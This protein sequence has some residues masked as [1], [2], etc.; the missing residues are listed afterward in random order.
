M[1]RRRGPTR[2]G[3][4]GAVRPRRERT[5]RRGARAR[6]DRTRRRPPAAVRP[7]RPGLPAREGPPGGIGQ[8]PCRRRDVLGD[9]VP[10]EVPGG[11]RGRG[12]GTASQS[13][14]RVDATALV[15]PAARLPQV[16][17][18]IGE[19]LGP[20]VP[21][22]GLFP[23]MPSGDTVGDRVQQLGGR[24]RELGAQVAHPARVHRREHQRVD[25]DADDGSEQRLQ[26]PVGDVRGRVGARR[27]NEQGGG[28]RVEAL[29]AEAGVVAPRRTV[30]GRASA[31]AAMVLCV[32]TPATA[33]R[34]V[35]TTTTVSC[36]IADSRER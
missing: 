18:D 13:Q 14:A 35:P 6:H 19:A 16:R 12:R 15:R 5:T 36:C 21:A 1:P 31:I 2:G 9:L 3:R 4:P 7:G 27:E 26:E 10:V 34:S 20:V 28:R 33:A 11:R 24:V 30:S 8:G 32:S 22:A 25:A 17:D 29:G 23:G